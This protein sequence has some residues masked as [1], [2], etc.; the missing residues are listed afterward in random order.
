MKFSVA[1]ILAVTLLYACGCE[2][3][4]ILLGDGEPVQHAEFGGR[5]RW[6]VIPYLWYDKS[7]NITC[8]F[9]KVG[10]KSVFRHTDT[11]L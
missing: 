9:T 8:P 4:S 1:M 2:G 3:G 7:V 11:Q 5:A 6:K 10:L